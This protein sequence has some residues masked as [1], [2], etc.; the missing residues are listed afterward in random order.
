MKHCP[1]CK[2]DKPLDQFYNC[3]SRKDGKTGHCKKCHYAAGKLW[4]DRHPESRAEYH[5]RSLYKIE[6]E[7]YQRIL[8]K[9]GNCCGICK[10]P[11]KKSRNWGVDH[12]HK[13]GKVRGV[14]CFQCNNGLGHFKD[15]VNLLRSGIDYLVSHL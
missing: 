12:C 13:T 15:S 14:L 3:K 4:L 9:Q 10:E 5:R 1:K 7:D 6:P 11:L 8:N 2:T